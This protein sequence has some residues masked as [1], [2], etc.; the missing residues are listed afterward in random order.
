M[1][2]GNSN[3]PYDLVKKDHFLKERWSPPLSLHRFQL[4]IRTA[5]AC[6]FSCKKAQ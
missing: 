3:A 5:A 6:Y 2:V 4:K 1:V